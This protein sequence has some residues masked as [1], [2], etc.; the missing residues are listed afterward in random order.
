MI[1]AV[2]NKLFWGFFRHVMTDRQYAKARY[3]LSTGEKLNLDRPQTFSEKINWL[4]LYDRSELRKW[5]A[6][7]VRVRDFVA[8]RIGEEYLI[9]LIGV[10]DKLNRD[11]WDS[12]PLQFVIKA[13]HGSG[14][15]RIVRDKESEQFEEIRALTAQWQ[16]TDYASFGR[17]WVYRELPRTI[18]A[19]ELLLTDEGVV[20]E[21]FKFFCFHGRV[22]YIQVD[23]DRFNNQ[24]RNMYDRN[25]RK[26]D[27]E[28]LHPGY[29]GNVP[30]PEKLDQ[31]IEIAEKL[32]K[33]FRFVRVDLYLLHNRI[34]FGEM[35]NFPGNG[36]EPFNPMEYDHRFGSLLNIEL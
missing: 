22:Q 5:V 3:W 25:F 7:R 8:E 26:L 28:I 32:S 33:D 11:I 23:F 27:L 14:M 16:K 18:I 10:Y 2:L 24:K 9:P 4:K 30:E 13:N 36:F 20:P 15:I 17:E 12:L 21:D 31:A 1:R 19:E 34:L 35:T 6:D 29:D